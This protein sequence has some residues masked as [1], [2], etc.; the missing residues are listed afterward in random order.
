MTQSLFSLLPH[1]LL[2]DDIG[3]ANGIAVSR[4][5]KYFRGLIY[6]YDQTGRELSVGFFRVSGGHMQVPIFWPSS[7]MNIADSSTYDKID[8]ANHPSQPEKIEAKVKPFL[9]ETM[10]I[11]MLEI[12][13]GNDKPD[14]CD[15]KQNAA[16]YITCSTV[17]FFVNKPQCQNNYQLY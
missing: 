3:L 14:Q 9:Q 15:A 16:R 2:N 8:A 4:R 10:R 5:S 12:V 6:L 13:I 7:V 11:G 1:I 17:I